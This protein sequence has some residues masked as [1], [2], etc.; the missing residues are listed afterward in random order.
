MLFFF[1][2]Q[3]SP[4]PLHPLPTLPWG[5][6]T[7]LC[8]THTGTHTHLHTHAL[9][10]SLSLSLSPLPS[11]SLPWLDLISENLAQSRC[12]GS[13]GGVTALDSGSWFE[14]LLLCSDNSNAKTIHRVQASSLCPLQSSA[15]AL[16]WLVI[17]PIFW[18]G[19]LR[20]KEA[21]CLIQD[22]TRCDFSTAT[23]S[24]WGSGENAPQRVP[25]KHL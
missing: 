21:K 19:K 22:H 15:A 5:T 18:M 8:H 12:W 9:L 1:S 10:F 14:S 24:S 6:C 2:S 4:S 13:L 17:I 11:C 20:L 23:G 7:L 3:F 16:C 25:P